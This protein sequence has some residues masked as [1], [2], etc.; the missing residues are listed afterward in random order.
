MEPRPHRRK[1]GQAILESMLT[2]L[3][4]CLLVAGLYQLALIF[5]ARDIL[6]HAARSAAR[7]RAVGFNSWMVEKCARVASIPNAGKMLTPDTSSYISPLA[8]FIGTFTPGQLWDYA[9]TNSEWEKTPYTN[10]VDDIGRYLGSEDSQAGSAILDYQDWDT[11][12]HQADVSGLPV[13]DAI[14]LNPQVHAVVKQDFPMRVPL[15]GAF[16]GMDHVTLSGEC[17]M[18]AHYGQYI[19]DQGL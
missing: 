9:L 14:P 2:I 6:H 5:A 1:R 10:E 19:D 17:Y 16:W 11:I 4:L 18:E 3:V 12:T 8:D 7:A 13:G 15:R